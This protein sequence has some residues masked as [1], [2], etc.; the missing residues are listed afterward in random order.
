M[1]GI[2]AYLGR[3]D[4]TNFVLEGIKILRNRGYDSMGCCSISPGQKGFVVTKYAQRNGE[5]CYQLLEKNFDVHRGQTCMVAHTRWATTGVVND[6]NSHP[7]LDTLT[8]DGISIVHNGI[9]N[10]YQQLKEFLIQQGVEFRSETDTEVIVNLISYY[11][12]QKSNMMDAIK[13]TLQELDGTWALIIMNRQEPDNLYVCKKGSPILVG[14]SEDMCIISSEISGFSNHLKNYHVIPDNHILKVNLSTT[15]HKI[16]FFRDE[17]LTEL[18][19]HTLI[20]QTLHETTPTPYPHWT[21]KE[22]MEQ[23]NA[24]FRATNQGGRIKNRSRVNL[25]GLKEHVETLVKIK[26]LIILASGTSLHAGMVGLKYFQTLSGFTT[27]RAI[28]ASEFTLLDL[29]DRNVG[30]LMLSQ[31]GETRDLV[32]CLEIIRENRPEVT[33]FSIV[34]VVESIIAREADCGIYLNAGREVGVASTKSFTNQLVVLILLAV[35]FSQNR[36]KN[37]NLRSKIISS[38][39]N[40]QDLITDTLNQIQTPCNQIIDRLAKHQHLFVLGRDKGYP[41]AL[42]GALKIKEISYIHAEAYPGGG[43]K[44]G[45]L[46]LIS[47]GT[48]VIVVRIGDSELKEKLDIAAEETKSRGAYLVSISNQLCANRGIYDSEILIADDQHLSPLLAVIPLQYLAYLLSLK[49]GQN[50]DYPRNLAKCVTVD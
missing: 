23:A 27:I 8:P 43:L 11:Y 44:H 14:Y 30:V 12:Q 48:P 40:L 15:D 13:L 4:G 20:H 32:H 39:R 21:L 25:G 33:I 16:R 6:V 47:Q 29:P 18:S 37:H 28:D 36:N 38:L 3:R 45:P 22:I 7:H 41:I 19:T 2:I 9:I 46:A 31:S 42:E 24:A 34:N 5:D 26:H 17:K 1:C 10:N 35:W 50:P 49:L